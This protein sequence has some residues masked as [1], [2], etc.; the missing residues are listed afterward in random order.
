MA[1]APSRA[2]WKGAIS[3]GLVHIPVSL[4]TAT[5]DLRPKMKMIDAATGGAVGYRKYDKSTGEDLQAAEVAKGVEVDA[6]RYVTLSKDEIREALPRSTQLIEIEAFVPLHE[7]PTVFYNKPYYVAPQG[8]AQK[9]YA[10]LR[11]VLRRTGKAGLG[12]VVVSS[13]QHLALVVPFGRG[14]VVNLLR[15]SDEVR[16]IDA[17]DLPGD[18]AEAGLAERELQ[19]G[20]QLVLGLSE[21]WQPDRF[22][23][24]FRE[25][26]EALVEAKR[27]AGEVT[28]A[29]QAAEEMP[30]PAGGEVIDLTELLRKSLKGAAAA[31]PP[32]PAPAAPRAAKKKPAPASSPPAGRRRGAANDEERAAAAAAKGS[33]KARAS[34]KPATP[35]RRAS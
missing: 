34:T 6:G 21:G 1:T 28:H 30:Q 19:M 25:K 10:L 2:I 31:S 11:E 26:V 5:Q 7:V 8:R 3:F 27:Q 33:E 29:A 24:E 16:D 18:A 9:V 23:D 20:E 22:H 14:L 17:L 32:A 15:W 4:H 13:R 35:R 12:R